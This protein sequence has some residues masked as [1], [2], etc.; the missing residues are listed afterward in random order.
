MIY[1]KT[2]KGNENMKKV[3]HLGMAILL[4]ITITRA[5]A[6]DSRNIR[7]G[8]VLPDEGYC[9]QPYIVKTHDGSWLCVMTT[10]VGE[11]G[12]HEQHIVSTFSKDKGK[13]WSPFVDIEPADGPEASWVMPL[14]IPSGRIYVFYTYNKNNIRWVPNC[15]SDRLQRRVDTLG[16]YMFRFSD[17]HGHS[18]SKRY[19]IPV[20]SMRIDKNNNFS[21]DVLLFWGVGKPII[22]KMD[23]FFGFAKIGHWGRPGGMV[24]SQGCFMKSENI[25]TE[26]DPEKIQWQTL[27]DGDE[28][29]QA[30]K[31]AV[32]DE[33]NIVSM[34][35]GSLYCTYRTIDGYMCHG[36][37]RD[38]GHTWTTSHATYSPQGRRIK[39]SRAHCPVSKFSN[40]KYLLWFHNHGGEATHKTYQSYYPGRN[41]V[42]VCGGIEKNGQLYWSE[43]EILLYDVDPQVRISYPDFVE[44]EGEYYVTETQKTIARIHKIDPDLLETV[45]NQFDTKD[46]T[47]DG[48]V[49]KLEKDQL[50]PNASID[51]PFLPDL[52]DDGFTIDFW[53]KAEH[54]NG[55]QTILD[56]RD[57]EGRGIVLEISDRSTINLIMNDGNHQASWDSDPGTH[58]GTLKANEWQHVAVVVDGGPN[59]I[60]FIVNGTFCD[61]GAVRD[62]GFGWFDDNMKNVNGA[63][64]AKLSQNLS[65]EIRMLRIYD[66]YLF[67]SKV[68]G[69]YR[70]DRNNMN[71]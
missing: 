62:Y 53:I 40:G 59:I 11:E 63:Q 22:H 10:G 20:R 38:G 55:G 12:D 24:I 21:G 57:Q 71:D 15:N 65:G 31:R 19:E 4:V 33:T 60:S 6:V 41:P 64:K 7:T 45:W 61:G 39:H 50:G 37:S 42:W 70:A 44:E 23:M 3:F 49:V 35:D 13:T 51:M 2:I 27:P 29:L 54:L 9:D 14:I 25:L 67:T 18:W 17:D 43:P 47:R 56:N 36:Y 5:S 68:I 48:L 69:N 8:V 28:G 1:T 30:P 16:E 46:E 58:P 32:A 66:R 52:T 34:N 26:P